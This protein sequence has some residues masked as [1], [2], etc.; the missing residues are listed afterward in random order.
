MNIFLSQSIQTQI[1]LEEIADVKRQIITPATSRTII[2]IVQDGLIGAYNLTSP[3]M[4]IDWKSAMNIISYTSMDDFK[5]FKK[6]DYSGHE[7][8][9]LIIP[10][11]INVA[12]IDKERPEKTLIIKNGILEKGHLTKDLLGS[13]KKNNLT[14][15]IW[16][17]YGVE[18][19]RKFLD[20][21]QR[22]VNNFNLY[23]G[24]TVG[25]GDAT[26]GKDVETQINRLFET[27]DLKVAHMITELE[28]NPD[29]MD[30]D[31]FERTL[32]AELNVIRED[33]SKL[34]MANLSP[35]N[36]FNIM[37]S[38]G[39]KGDATNM[40]QMSGCLGLQAFEGKLVPKK[41]NRRTLPYFARDDDRSA[42]R[43]LVNRPFLKGLTFPQFFFLNLSGREGLIEQAIK[44]V[45]G[46]TLVTIMEDGVA[47]TLPIGNWVD[48]HLASRSGDVEH[49]KE[50]DMELLRLRSK[51][52][53]PTTDADDH[54]TWGEVTAV[55]RHDPGKELYKIR[56]HG[57][58]DVIV[59]ESKS[60]LIWR[61]GKF[62]ETSTPNVKVGDHV[63]VT[64]SLPQ[65]PVVRTHI[66]MTD[67]FP[68]TEYLYGSDF[69]TAR[70]MVSG[71]MVGRQ[72]IPRGWW[73]QNN[74]KLFTLP[75]ERVALLNRAGKRSKID[76]IKPGYIYP[77]STS[78]DHILIPGRFEL[79]RDNGLFL[80]LFLAEGNADIKSGY[81]QITNQNQKVR[82]FVKKWFDAHSISHIEKSEINHIGGTTTEVRGFSTILGK[83]LTK[84]VGHGARHKFVPNEAFNAPE[85]FIVGLLDGYIS[86]D[87][88][89]TKNSL[90]VGSASSDLIRGISMLCS[91]LGI[92]GKITITQ[93]KANNL[94][95]EDIAPTHMFSIRGQW[96]RIFAEKVT[97]T[98]DDKDK[99]LKKMAPSKVHKNFKE[100]NDVV[101]DQIVSIEKVDVAQYPKVY[102]LTVPSTENFGLANGLQVRD[103]AE[104]GYIQR[105]LIKMMEDGMIK[106]DMTVRTASNSI[107]QFT[108][109]DTGADTTKQYDYTMKLLE[110]NNTDIASKHRF[111]KEE[112]KSL[113]TKFTEAD[114]EKYYRYLLAVRDKLRVA[115]IKTRMNYITMSVIYMLPVNLTR[116]VDN[117]KNDS[118]LKSV[119]TKEKLDPVYILSRLEHVLDNRVTRLKTMRK[120]DRTDTTSVKYQD[121]RIAKTS[122]EVALHDSLSPK[123][124]L[125]E[126]QLNR[127]QFDAIIEAVIESYNGNIAEP[128]EMVGIIAA[129]SLGEP[130]TQLSQIKETRIRLSGTVKY[131]G[132]IGAFVDA[133]M[134]KNKDWVIQIRG[135]DEDGLESSV[136]I[137]AE[138]EDYMIASVSKDE[139]V[140]WKRISEISRHPAKGK[141]IKVT[142]NSGKTTTATLSHSFLK[143]H[144]NQIEPIKGSQL[145]IGDRIP[146][147][148]S[149]PIVD[150]PITEVESEGVRIT[151][152]KDFGWLCG[153]FVA[154]GRLNGNT[155]CISKILPEF[156]EQIRKLAP[157]FGYTVTTRVTEG[158]IIMKNKPRKYDD[159]VY[160]GKMISFNNKPIAKFLEKNFS[161][162]SHNKKVSGLIYSAN[163]EFLAGLVSGYFDGDGSVQCDD[164]HHNIR[165]H[166][167]SEQL[168][169]DMCV[170]VNF[171]GMH[172]TKS[173]EIN[174]DQTE[175]ADGGVYNV[176][177]VP[178]KYA[179][180]FKTEIGLV[181]KEKADL[182]DK[183]IAYRNR[184]D[185]H[186][187]KEEIDMIPGLGDTIASISKK[188][189]M[190]G[191][192][193]NFKRFTKK[194]AIGRQ[195]L[196]KIIGLFKA[197]IAIQTHNHT[198]EGEALEEAYRVGLERYR[199][200]KEE[201]NRTRKDRQAKT[202]QKLD[203]F[204][205]KQ[206]NTQEQHA[207][208]DKV[209]ILED[210]YNA[211]VVWD[212]IIK[213]ELLDDPKEYVYDFTVPGLES[214]MV[215]TGIL[216]HNT[217]NSFHHSGIAAISTTTQGV[218]RI[219]ELLSLT[220]NLK[221]PQMIIYPT[222][223]YMGS[224]DM[225]NK[226]S[227][228]IKYTT[229]GHIRD[230]LTVYYDPDPQ[231]PGGFMEKDNVTK[232]FSSNSTSKYSC[233]SDIAGLPWLI[234]IEFNR[235]SLFEKE[236]TLLDI[237]SR[238]C[239]MWERRHSDKG[240]K[241]EERHVFEKITQVAILSNTDYDKTPIIHVRFYMT[242]FEESIVNDFIDHVVDRFKLKGIPSITN[243]SAINEER[244]LTFDNENNDIEKKK[245]YVIY[246]VGTNLYDIRYLNGIDIYKTI[247]N[248]VVAM[249]ETFGIEAA[250]ATLLREIIYAYERAGSGVNY[251][252]VSV[253]IDLMTFNGYLTSIDRHGMNKSDVGPLSRASFE[254]T[255][256]QLI[257]AAVFGE[258]DHMN[259]VSSRIMAG[260]VIKGGTGLC[261]VILD[262][263]MVQKSEFTEDIG[264]KYIKTY[265][266][267][268]KNNVIADIL[269]RPAEETPDIFIPV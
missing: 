169:A 136:Y 29:L 165:A 155:V 202:T 109:G 114:N 183:L 195:T 1:E 242:D 10:P 260:L 158:H 244:V 233:Q 34:L 189:A 245:Q 20:N 18:E 249:Y 52:Y 93:L 54:V 154:D 258:V 83:F 150:N 25:V 248:D 259:G 45:T 9:S 160:K 115:Q 55:T 146:I 2:G 103:T 112:L 125:V 174:Y 211:D 100:H 33:V 124:C 268:G 72:Q 212:E 91:R 22:L 237:K 204:S 15:L 118:R 58:R 147:A 97:L 79:N 269:D 191:Q 216:V 116:I 6:A 222:K 139:K 235:E 113:G 106:Y 177:H 181:V 161:N 265:N 68:K 121:D 166:S 148:R 221:T 213:L 255:V 21:T 217:L 170:L 32:F 164:G 162:G 178:V 122:L 207:I 63:P 219:K 230:R 77:F 119:A 196:G 17:E 159:R 131:S 81:V 69:I 263:D 66:N 262:T 145:K 252:H 231:A 99:Q 188:L 128:G 153:A 70:N 167:K 250:R 215:D 41:L 132:T 57:G 194:H 86:G 14:Q 28:N 187:D 102:D 182:L 75:Y 206:L 256:D 108:Y 76:N 144:N 64:M 208:N 142:T 129:Q 247:C 205:L 26:V 138:G 51:A 143:R 47:K 50:R 73:Q 82:T 88:T 101:L 117:N 104:S 239:S 62:T 173:T 111:T 36:N 266:E 152:D 201:R 8:F 134:E 149:I 224:R 67:Y 7:L 172:A 209:R 163:R 156:E 46:D 133:L 151:L 44:S 261:N 13:K 226:I 123:K 184:D 90:Q 11:K 31:L 180:K 140:Q 40:A 227:S 218:P 48:T 74:G 27:K 141:M 84:L 253:L 137:P 127:A 35:T 61:D 203:R 186:S 24:F 238:F 65:A 267:I 89:I 16:D 23:N 110:M 240:I 198:L 193:R 264:Q 19:T 220:K 200:K 192:S 225:A 12:R 37:I 185:K 175:Y 179:Q 71:V 120:Q 4:R 228:Y 229:L 95:T 246:T 176:I 78:R 80:G 223:E 241:K 96:A 214:F 199:V 232:V 126:L 197:E 130:T 87:G 60:L 190:E 257:T 30:L 85:E 92:F 135:P 59:T 251:H 210:A 56:T 254:K 98:E 5:S 157:R 171:F 236:V 234:R 107:I 49:H 168:I 243:I 43:G 105:K 94:G 3:N 39:S 38:S 53:V 42:S